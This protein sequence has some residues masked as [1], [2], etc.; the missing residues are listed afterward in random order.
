MGNS[1]QQWRMAIGTFGGGQKNQTFY[2]SFV[3]SLKQLALRLRLIKL[4]LVRAGV[5]QNPGPPT[6]DKSEVTKEMYELGCKIKACDQQTELKEQ[7]DLMCQLGQEYIKSATTSEIWYEHYVWS[8]ALYNAA[9]CRI[10]KLIKKQTDGTNTALEDDLEHTDKQLQ[11][12]ENNFV[13]K[14]RAANSKL[15]TEASTQKYT[16]TLENIRVYSNATVNDIIEKYMVVDDVT[17]E[18]KDEDED[19]TIKYSKVFYNGLTQQLLD[20]YKS[21]IHDC[22]SVLGH[23]DCKFAF[24]A[25]GSISRKEVTAYS[26]IEWAILFDP[27][28]KPVDQIKTQLRMIA[29]YMHLK[30][31]NLGETLLNCLD[32]P[33]LTD[34]NKHL[35]RDMKDNDFYD[36]ATTRGISFDGTQPWASKTAIGRKTGVDPNKPSRLEL[37][38][39]VDEMSKFQLTDESIKEGYHLSDVLMTS[40]LITGE[41][42]LWNEYNE[43]VHSILSSPSKTN[44]DITIGRERAL[45]TLEKDLKKYS[46]N[47]LSSESFTQKMH[48]KHDIYRFATITIN[49]LKLMHGCTSFA[50]LDVLEELRGKG[51]LTEGAAKDLQI[52]VCSVINLRHMVYGR[53]KQQKEF[54]SFLPRDSQDDETTEVMPV[55]SFTAILRFFNTFI[56]WCEFL[57][58]NLNVS[59]IWAYR[60]RYREGNNEVKAQLY[61][62]IFFFDRALHSYKTELKTLQSQ[63]AGEQEWK[64]ASIKTA[65]GSLYISQGNYSDALSYYKDILKVCRKINDENWVSGSLNNIGLVYNKM[66]DLTEAL[67]YHQECLTMLRLIH[68]DS[69]HPDVAMSLNNIG[70]VYKDMG[71][72]TKALEYHQESLKMK[73]QIHKDSP[74]PNVASSLNNIG[75]VY[76]KMG[77]LTKALEYH[78]ESL[79]MYRLIYKDSPHPNVASSLGNIG[80]V[81]TNMGDLTKAL[82]YHQESLTMYRLIYKDSPHPNVASSLGNIG[83]VY[84]NMGDLTKALEY[85]QECLTMLR[86][87]HKDSP[88]PDVASSLGNIDSPHPNVALSLNNIGNVYSKM[89]DLTKALEYHQESLTMYRLIYKDSPHPNVAGSLGNIGNVYTNMGDLTK[90]LEYHQESLTMYRL[91]YKDS[92]HPNLASS[93]GNIGNVYKNMGDLTKT[94]EYHQECLTMQRLIHKDSPHPAV[95]SSLGNISLVYKNMGDLTKALEYHQECLTML[96]LIHKDSPHPD[97]ASSLGNIGLVYN[98]MGDLTKALEYHQECLTMLR[99]IYKDSPHPDVASS[100]NNIGLVYKNMGDLTKA[101]EYQHKGLRM[102]RLIHKDNPHPSVATVL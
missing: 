54:I 81:Y 49:I 14:C 1:A 69:P 98:D 10:K 42:A 7:A 87:I 4:L 94:L 95:A 20:F 52:M 102:Y 90:A 67:E 8:C 27:L 19:N 39:T 82:E 77:D 72:L 89:G 100:L 76:S 35:P 9:K 44:P 43:I 60:E 66:G 58:S 63:D 96:R 71:N 28:D 29:Y 17:T 3:K 40:T 36:K 50:P 80:N 2:S 78:Q 46:E 12:I 23:P 84:K 101:L 30:V 11:L 15:S 33:V 24:L 70:L 74:H 56:P 62:N 5:E 88:H 37:I 18:M 34:Y 91:I 47:P 6:N 16:N 61:E 75:N 25:L 26:D 73:K 93:L 97:V 22:I 41:F 83:N 92:P 65:I 86:L 38:M 57:K 53:Y 64:I 51:I 13:K 68:K 55:R 48:T 85:H 99:L 59:G 32:I 45:R 31:L 79:T 21:I